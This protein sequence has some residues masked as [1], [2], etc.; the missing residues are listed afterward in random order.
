[1]SERLKK[2]DTPGRLYKPTTQNKSF[3]NK[4]KII[5]VKKRIKALN[6][7]WCYWL[8]EEKSNKINKFRFVRQELYAL[9]KQWI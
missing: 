4:N 3:F 1:M 2:K 7:G 8:S 9:N 6:D 5:I